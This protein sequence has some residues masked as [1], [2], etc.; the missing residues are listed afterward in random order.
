MHCPHCKQPIP[1]N[2]PTTDLTSSCELCGTSFTRDPHH[3]YQRFC[4]D[5]CRI[6]N[7]RRPA[8]E[9]TAPPRP[10]ATSN[11][12]PR[13][14]EGRGIEDGYKIALDPCDTYRPFAEVPGYCWC[15]WSEG[16]HPRATR[17][18]K[19]ARANAPGKPAQGASVPVSAPAPSTRSV[20][21]QVLIPGSKPPP[22]IGDRVKFR[23]GAWA[24]EY[25]VIKYAPFHNCAFGV[26]V[27]SRA[28]GANADDIEV[29]EEA[30]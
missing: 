21:R 6:R 3:R 10:P 4:S 13:E 22:K 12:G 23:T 9:R 16:D 17:S 5:K 18:P 28:I 19:V 30:Q 15:G 29:I 7:H 14:L 8:S 1:P 2:P 25:G 11:E 20:R 24:G 27:I 26:L